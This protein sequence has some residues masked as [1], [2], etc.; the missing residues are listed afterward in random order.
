MVR[1]KIKRKVRY[2]II[3]FRKGK[4]D[5]FFVNFIKGFYVINFKVLIFYFIGCVFGRICVNYR[6]YFF[7]RCI[8]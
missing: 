3:I 5:E 1:R 4:V 7:S 8:F 2:E 6:F